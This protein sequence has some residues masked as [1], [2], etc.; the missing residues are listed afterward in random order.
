[1]PIRG[2]PFTVLVMH[3]ACGTLASPLWIGSPA[4]SAGMRYKD[5]AGEVCRTSVVNFV[6][7]GEYIG[8]PNWIGVLNPVG[9][10]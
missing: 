7:S 10:P 5:G 4:S 6:S 2:I 8:H 1:M 3:L 9:V